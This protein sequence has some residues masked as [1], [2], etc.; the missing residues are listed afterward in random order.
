V[1]VIAN[2]TLNIVLIVLY[3]WVGAAVATTTSVAISLVLAY[4]HVATIIDLSFPTAEIAKQSLA[5]IVMAGI[6]YGGLTLEN[7]YRLLGHNVATVI[8]LVGTGSSIYF[9]ILFGIS[10]QFR[11]TLKRNLP[12]ELPLS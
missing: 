4:R 1:F 3:G 8:L 7:A 2:V 11:E 6:V 12:F 10:A 5:A 9:L